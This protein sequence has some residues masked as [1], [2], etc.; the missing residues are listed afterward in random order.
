MFNLISNVNMADTLSLKIELVQKDY[1][2]TVVNPLTN[3]PAY[4]LNPALILKN[5]LTRDEVKQLIQLHQSKIVLFN[6]AEKEI[7]RVKLQALVADLEN[8]EFEIQACSKLRR[9]KNY[10]RWF[11][12]PKCTCPKVENE[13]NLST[14]KRVINP[15]CIA[16]SSPPQ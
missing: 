10:H 13:Q 5:K 1:D 8:L 12:F 9:D 7:D 16:H 3:K 6:E 2:I 14:A 4:D 11:D 15:N